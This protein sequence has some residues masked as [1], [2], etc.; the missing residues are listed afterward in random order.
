MPS[1]SKSRLHRAMTAE[2]RV[3]SVPSA[4]ADMAAHAQA[5][6]GASSAHP[7]RARGAART[8][9]DHSNQS[10]SR[11]ALLYRQARRRCVG[12]RLTSL[13]SLVTLWEPSHKDPSE[14]G[15][16]PR[17]LAL[18][19]EDSAKNPRQR[20][21]RH[22]ARGCGRHGDLRARECSKSHLAGWLRQR[23]SGSTCHDQEPQ[24]GIWR[25]I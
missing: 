19:A 7:A 4:P 24:P 15:S 3:T 18:S 13:S 21:E 2:A 11:R 6:G 14:M 22:L 20:D 17:L 25:R 16:S 5:I 10:G 12:R 8:R 1:E 9:D 23:W